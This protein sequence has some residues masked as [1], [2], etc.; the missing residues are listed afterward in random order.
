MPTT[1]KGL[2]ARIAKITNSAKKQKTKNKHFLLRFPSIF[3]PTLSI[4]DISVLLTHWIPF[5]CHK[6]MQHTLFTSLASKKTF[7][8][9]VCF[10]AIKM[11]S[12]IICNERF[13][14]LQ[15]WPRLEFGLKY[16]SNPFLNYWKTTRKERR[17]CRCAINPFFTLTSRRII[18]YGESTDQSDWHN[19]H[20]PVMQFM[21]FQE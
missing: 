17:N 12:I 10:F 14:V 21:G 11:Q 8:C 19:M 20:F 5:I 6:R 1:A 18:W 9:F 15:S 4:L 7:F 3:L 13:F 16:F 2:L